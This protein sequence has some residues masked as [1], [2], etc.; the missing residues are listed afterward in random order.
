MPR[1]GIR[2][3]PMGRVPAC[4]VWTGDG[5]GLARRL[6]RLRCAALRL[7]SYAG[8][9][10]F[11]GRQ[12]GPTR[13]PGVLRFAPAGSSCPHRP[14]RNE[15]EA[16]LDSNEE[17]AM[18]EAKPSNGLLIA[19]V[20]HSHFTASFFD[21]MTSLGCCVTSLPGPVELEQT[22]SA[23]RLIQLCTRLCTRS[24]IEI[25]PHTYPRSSWFEST[26]KDQAATPTS[27]SA[28]PS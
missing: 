28:S 24:R 1:S 5:L 2:Q 22:D 14:C 18:A 23:Y 27:G 25:M 12:P 6:A 8:S 10:F 26:R 21:R 11:S 19:V 9:H 16:A 13:L 15:P 3:D 7:P 17:N 4:Q 20:R